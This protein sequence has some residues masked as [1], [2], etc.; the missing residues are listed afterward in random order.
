M[1]YEVPEYSE[2]YGR[3]HVSASGGTQPTDEHILKMYLRK[4][5]G[6]G[7]PMSSRPRAGQVVQ[8][9]CDLHLGLDDYS[10]I[11][12][13]KQ[14]MDITEAINR[15]VQEFKTFEPLTWDNGMDAEAK[16]QFAEHLATMAIIAMQ[17]IKEFFGD[18][19]IEGEYRRY[20]QDPRLDV[21]V[22]LLLD[23]SAD[24]KQ[25]DLKCSL[26]LR[27]PPKKDGTRTWRVPK[28]RT[29]PTPQQVMQQ[30]VYWK[31]TGLRPG[32]LFVTAEG[33]H[34]ATEDNC[35]ALKPEALEE[36]Y[37]QIVGR[38]LV[39]QNL[40]KAAQGNWKKLFSMVAPDYSMISS[41]HGPEVLQIAKQAWRME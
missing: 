18:E 15:G 8:H 17:G 37:E 25:L 30:A 39:V 3:Y 27:N 33:Y 38:W 35:E 31:A 5:H 6:M 20:Y 7:F 29:E 16:E 26:P 9:I 19:E 11:Y 34:I 36:A 14:G 2:H 32:L 28:P 12:G 4:E 40:M 23:Y 13:A 41:R 22:L 10:P 1:D 21:P 24:D